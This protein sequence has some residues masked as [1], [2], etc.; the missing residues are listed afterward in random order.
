MDML[1]AVAALL[2]FAIGVATARDV[3][4]D[5]RHKR[6]RRAKGYIDWP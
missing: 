3:L 1:K 6:V 2:L 4:Q 5:E